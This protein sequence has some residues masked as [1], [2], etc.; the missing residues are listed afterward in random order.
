[1]NNQF[2]S[3]FFATIFFSLFMAALK[4]LFCMV[5]L[6]FFFDFRVDV[7]FQ[8][9]HKLTIFA[10]D[11]PEPFPTQTKVF[12]ENLIKNQRNIQ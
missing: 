5:S 4:N 8:K 12:D 10:M 6:G 3:L 2:S 7:S 1:M 9:G 11:F